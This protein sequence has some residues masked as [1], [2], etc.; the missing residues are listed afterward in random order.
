MQLAADGV[1]HFAVG[2][3]SLGQVLHDLHNIVTSKVWVRKV[4]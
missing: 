4:F 2:L 3:H 1:Q